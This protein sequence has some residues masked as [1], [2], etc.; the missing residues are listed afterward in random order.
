MREPER[1]SSRRPS[2]LPSSQFRESAAFRALSELGPDAA[3]LEPVEE[4]PWTDKDTWA[5]PPLEETS[6]AVE[7]QRAEQDC[8][9]AME[10][11]GDA[12]VEAKA[13]RLP[14]PGG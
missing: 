4:R 10:S 6:G 5:L 11:L 13:K 2:L 7:A 3:A 14:K 1:P 12:V 9:E 8:R